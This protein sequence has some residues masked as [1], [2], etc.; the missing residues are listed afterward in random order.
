[1]GLLGLLA[2]L[3]D[4]VLQ[5]GQALLCAL[6]TFHHVANFSFESA[7]LSRGFVQV[8]L[9]LIE[10]IAGFV[11]SLANRL[12]V[13]LDVSQIGSFGLEVQHSLL[14]LFMQTGLIRRRLAATQKPQLML[15]QG[16]VGLQGLVLLRHLGLTLEFFQVGIEFAQDVLDA[17]EVLA[18]VAQAVF[19]FAAT[20]LVLGHP[21]CLLEEQAQFLGLGFDDA[22]DGALSNDGVGAR[23]QTRTQK[24]VLDVTTTHRLVVDVIAAG[25]IAGQ[26][27]L[28]RDLGELAPLTACAMI[29][30]VKHQFHTGTA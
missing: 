4:L 12:E 9:R 3:G 16:D 14:H 7:H 11:M 15:L 2:P 10:L 29:R 24:H 18:C 27:P 8:A 26:H 20:F 23:S 28:D 1:M 19:G 25:A 6:T 5:L 22:A 13:S 17:G 30:V 21:R